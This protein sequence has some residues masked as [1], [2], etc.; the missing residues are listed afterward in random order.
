LGAFSV[1]HRTDRL[2]L[3]RDRPILLASKDTSR[4]PHRADAP[5]L[6]A[7]GSITTTS[8]VPFIEQNPLFCVAEALDEITNFRQGQSLDLLQQ[9]FGSGV[10]SLIPTE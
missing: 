6:A 2:V 9:L 3:Y 10:H 1:G 8:R 5:D 7:Y 4:N